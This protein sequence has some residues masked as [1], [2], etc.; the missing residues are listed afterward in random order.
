MTKADASYWLRENKRR[1]AAA[2]APSATDQDAQR[3]A[4]IRAMFAGLRERY[5]E[6]PDLVRFAWRERP[7]GTNVY[8]ILRI[9][10]EFRLPAAARREEALDGPHSA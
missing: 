7:P 8:E 3:R 10:E 1:R 6:E 9:A 2:R 5:P 4:S